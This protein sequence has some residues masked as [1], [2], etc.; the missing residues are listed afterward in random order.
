[1][2]EDNISSLSWHV[3]LFPAS[4][5]SCRDLRSNKCERWEFTVSDM[6]LYFIASLEIKVNKVLYCLDSIWLWWKLILLMC[7]WWLQI[8]ISLNQECVKAHLVHPRMCVEQFSIGARQLLFSTV[9]EY[10]ETPSNYPLHCHGLNIRRNTLSGSAI[11]EASDESCV[12]W[13]NQRARLIL[14]VVQTREGKLCMFSGRVQCKLQK[15]FTTHFQYFYRY[16]F[17]H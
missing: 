1:M 5:C 10:S 6:S 11:Y 17:L 12:P 4:S 9:P 2:T 13:C 7:A 16:F 14:E 3:A 8:F 15:G